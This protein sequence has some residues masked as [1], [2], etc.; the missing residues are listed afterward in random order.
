[1]AAAAPGR[2][3]QLLLVRAVSQRAG[4]H[5]EAD[6]EWSCAAADEFPGSF[7]L[8]S[9]RAWPATRRMLRHP[10]QALLGLRHV[11][12]LARA[13]RASASELLEAT[14]EDRLLKGVL[15]FHIA[16]LPG[17]SPSA[18]GS[19]AFGFGAVLHH[20]VGMWRPRGGSGGLVRALVAAIEAHGGVVR[21]GAPVQKICVQ[22]RSAR[23]VRL[24]DGEEIEA[25]TL[26]AA[27][28]PQTTFLRLL[29]PQSVPPK[30]LRAIERLEI[31]N[32]YALKVDYLIDRLPEWRPH[33]LARSEDQARATAYMSPSVEALEAAYRDY[34]KL[35][36]PRQ[37]A[38]IVSTP[39]AA[40]VDLAPSGS[41]LLTVE[42][43][44]TPYRLG[45]GRTWQSAREEVGDQLFR[46][47]QQY[48]PN[49]A[50]A[51]RQ[52]CV[53]TPEDLE[54]DLGLPRCQILHIDPS[55]AQSLGRRPLP[56]LADYRT[57]IR[58]LYLTGAGTHPG[59]GVW[60]APGHNA[61]QEILADL[62]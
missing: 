1:M 26:V 34:E 7:L 21:A 40:D 5:R 10:A 58:G 24:A 37:P 3:G 32:G 60:G 16:G 17:V 49:L 2:P 27:C 25:R 23:A 59:G 33:S 55:A 20:L 52:R 15:A 56:S 28:D 43:R 36:N 6:N 54:R 45:R 4:S 35:E 29:E 48:A 42:T 11:P 41:H 38:L 44:Y 14:F 47:V 39:T 62:G 13:Q 8:G 18:P 50:G 57:P 19:A 51:Q 61:A 31:A 9:P 12:L 53:Q 46:I 30:V 22:A